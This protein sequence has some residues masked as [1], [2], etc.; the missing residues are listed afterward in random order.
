MAL[1][2]IAPPAAE[3]VSLDE[4]KLQCRIDQT[5]E[6]T[7]LAAWIAAAREAA[8]HMTQRAF[9]TQTWEVALDAFP[10]ALDEPA[11]SLPR[12]PVIA[13]VSVKYDDTDGA[14]QTLD[15]AAYLLDSYRE[16]ARLLLAEG[17][18]WP[19]TNGERNS[20]R[21]RYTAGYGDAASDVPQGIRSWMLVR[22]ASL[23]K[24]REEVAGGTLSPLAY[25]DRL[26]DAYRVWSM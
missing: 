22:V 13:V 5:V 16:P 14:E 18:A 6:D 23:Y 15:P 26:L 7:L 1:K 25:T 19:A 9:I 8:E 12:P 10:A 24:H 4:A 20:V 17:A 11:I 3:P 2:L 21:I